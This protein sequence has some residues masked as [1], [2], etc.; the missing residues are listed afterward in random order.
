MSKDWND[1]PSDGTNYCT[2]NENPESYLLNEYVI[3]THSLGSQ[4]SI[5]GL[6]DL[7]AKTAEYTQKYNKKIQITIYMFANQ[8]PAIA[9]ASDRPAITG[10]KEKYC[11]P[12]GEF[13]SQ[14]FADNTEIVAFSDPND[15]LSYSIPDKFENKYIDSRLCPDVS[16]VLVNVAPISNIFGNENANPLA[17]HSNYKDDTRVIKLIINGVNNKTPQEKPKEGCYIVRTK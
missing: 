2:F 9:I 16:N 4:I 1:I 5:D 17:A 3:I 10:Q 12:K 8:L 11:S 14:R 7:A 13:Y 15:L 6:E